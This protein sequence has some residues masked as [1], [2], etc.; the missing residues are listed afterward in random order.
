MAIA[1]EAFTVVVKNEAIARL[2]PGGAETFKSNI[3]NQTF[4]ADESLSR[5]SFMVEADAVTF[6]EELGSLGLRVEDGSD[7][8][9]CDAFHQEMRPDCDWLLMGTYQKSVIACLA[10][11]DIKTIVGPPGWDPATPKPLKFSTTAEA[12]KRLKYLRSGGNV[13]AY[14]DRVDNVEVYIGRTQAPLDL[15]FQQAGEIV[16]ANLR[17][18][19]AP[20]AMEEAKI[21]LHRAVEMLETVT[22]RAPDVWRARWMLGKAWHALDRPELAYEQLSKAFELERD[23]LANSKELA[24]ICLE[25]G[26]GDEAVRVATHAVGLSPR[27]PELVGNLALA[28][29]IAGKPKEAESTIRAAL[30]MN[31]EDQINKN[32][33]RI[34]RQVA[35]GE[36]AQPKKLADLTKK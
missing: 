18:P 3:P 4:C 8:V 6:F 33:L 11:E 23:E 20:P 2:Y 22:E 29:L 35:S 26:R 24:G 9:I 14:W 28:W 36:R 10:G 16:V 27:D 1:I 30:A 5:C 13:H 17:N 25:L 19:G 21:D 7:A 34:I 15:L 12:A 31:A 32:V